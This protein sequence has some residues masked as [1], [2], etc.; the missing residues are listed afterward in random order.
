LQLTR[1]PRGRAEKHDPAGCPV[2]AR[3]QLWG[4]RYLLQNTGCERTDGRFKPGNSQSV[5]PPNLACVK[6]LICCRGIPERAAPHD[7]HRCAAVVIGLALRCALNA[8][9]FGLR[10]AALRARP[11]GKTGDAVG[12]ARWESLFLGHPGAEFFRGKR[13]RHKK[14]KKGPRNKRRGPKQVAELHKRSK[15]QNRKR[16]HF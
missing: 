1:G 3:A 14:R 6:I 16:G 9:P 15:N 12:R 5:K 11:T 7:G 2:R 8:S 4:R 13:N 10:R